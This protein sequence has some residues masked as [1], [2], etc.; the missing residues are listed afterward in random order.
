MH[1]LGYNDSVSRAAPIPGICISIG[2][3]PALLVLSESVRYVTQVPIPL[4]YEVI[5]KNDNGIG[6]CITYFNSAHLA[7]GHCKMNWH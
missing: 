6:T 5:I 1:W 3:I 4:L 2:P 7:N